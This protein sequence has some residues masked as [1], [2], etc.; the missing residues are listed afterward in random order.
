VLLGLSFLGDSGLELSGLGRDHEDGTVGLGGSGDHVLDEISVSGGIDD[1]VVML[2]GLEL[3]EGDVDG[4]TSIS[5]GLEFVKNPGEGER[6]LTDLLC[7]FLELVDGSLI[8]S[9]AKVDQVTGG[10]G[11]S[12]IDVANNND[13]NMRFLLCHYVCMTYNP[14]TLL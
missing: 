14:T 6:S 3:G 5:L 8:N 7:F 12:G 11:F 4:D 13:V 9:S 2:L 1:G 10:S